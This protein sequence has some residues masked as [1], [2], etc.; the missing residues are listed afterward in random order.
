MLSTA[1]YANLED[2]YLMTRSELLDRLAI[3]LGG[4]VAEE[5]V[6][7]EISTGAQNDLQRATD[8]ARSMVTEYGMSD[9]LGLSTYER[10]RQPTF[11]PGGFTS[12]KAYSE[13]KAAQID[14]EVTRVMEEAH[15]RVR[16]ILLAHRNTLD[17]LARLL[18]Q[19]EVVQG[20]ELRK[21][22]GKISAQTLPAPPDR[23]RDEDVVS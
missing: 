8:I 2:R 23:N 14:D 15:Q 7:R 5:Q 21:M 1:T 18:S 12:N 16:G 22:L 20:V 13:K 3:L 19:E 6:F 9:S 11:F 10:P 17:E 4:R